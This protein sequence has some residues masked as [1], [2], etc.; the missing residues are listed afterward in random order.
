MKLGNVLLRI[1][2]Y[3]GLS[4]SKDLRQVFSNKTTHRDT[5]V[6]PQKDDRLGPSMSLMPSSTPF[7]V[8]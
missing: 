6:E 5:E 8:T 3:G 1:H 4:P 2:V 7:K